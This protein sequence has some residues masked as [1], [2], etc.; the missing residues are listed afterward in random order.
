MRDCEKSSWFALRGVD[1]KNFVPIMRIPLLVGDVGELN[2][3]RLKSVPLSS[4]VLWK[5]G[6]FFV[7]GNK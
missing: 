2:V 6:A 1:N 3:R 5:R 7:S 4:E